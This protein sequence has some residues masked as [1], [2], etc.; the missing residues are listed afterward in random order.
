[1]LDNVVGASQISSQVRIFRTHV[2]PLYLLR[3]LTT[4]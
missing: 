3:S 1:M 2:S 4:Y